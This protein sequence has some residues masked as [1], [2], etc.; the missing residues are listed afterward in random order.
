M[1]PSTPNSSLQ[2]DLYLLFQLKVKLTLL[3]LFIKQMPSHFI[4]MY[5]ISHYELMHIILD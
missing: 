2:E 5:L 3:L 1:V 4:Y